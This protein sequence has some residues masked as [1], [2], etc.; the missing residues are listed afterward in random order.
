M[1]MM[2]LDRCRPHSVAEFLQAA[3]VRFRD[4]RTLSMNHRTGA[5][6]LCGYSAEMI[7]KAATSG[8]SDFLRPKPSRSST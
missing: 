6:Y 4:A 8:R 1:P 7:L 3:M 5:I 2:L